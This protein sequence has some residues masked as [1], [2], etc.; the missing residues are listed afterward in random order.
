MRVQRNI[1]ASLLAICVLFIAFNEARPLLA[2]TFWAS[3]YKTLMFNCDQVMREHYIAKRA[4][5]YDSSPEN[6]RNLQASEL[7]LL[8][9]H[10]YDKLRKRMISWGLNGDDLSYIGIEALEEQDYELR[11]FVEIHEIRYQ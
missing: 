2:S 11:D 7:G 1:L 4:L 8:D 6:L 10:E 9:C 3:D 5:E